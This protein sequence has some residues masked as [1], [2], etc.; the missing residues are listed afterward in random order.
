MAVAEISRTERPEALVWSD[1]PTPQI[2]TCPDRS[3]QGTLWPQSPAALGGRLL[4][5]GALRDAI[6]AQKLVH[7]LLLVLRHVHEE[8]RE[9]VL[10]ILEDLQTVTHDGGDPLHPG[11]LMTGGEPP[12]RDH[13][14][15][16]VLRKLCHRHGLKVLAVE[17]VE[18]PLI[19]LCGG[20]THL[21][22]IKELYQLIRMYDL[23]VAT[24]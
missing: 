5:E 22:Q 11:W 14:L 1:S 19:E 23:P 12:P 13:A 10:N 6:L 9:L 24:R 8:E 18:L 16:E 21:R 15:R 3:S 17:P 2:A 4:E 7:G 20:L